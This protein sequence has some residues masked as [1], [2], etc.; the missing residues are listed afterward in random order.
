MDLSDV[1]FS[2]RT[3]CKRPLAS[4]AH[5]HPLMIAAS[6]FMFLLLLLLVLHLT[7]LGF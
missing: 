4:T 3:L 1:P 2:C 5:V 6:L 7:L